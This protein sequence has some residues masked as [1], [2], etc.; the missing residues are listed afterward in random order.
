MNFAL[1]EVYPDDTKCVLVFFSLRY[2][3]A[4]KQLSDMRAAWPG[5]S[6]LEMLGPFHAVL[7]LCPGGATRIGRDGR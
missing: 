5:A 3:V 1:P 4:R 6:N 7:F 2:A